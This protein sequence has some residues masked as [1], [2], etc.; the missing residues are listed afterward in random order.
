MCSKTALTTRP[1]G[2]TAKRCAAWTRPTWSSASDRLRSGTSTTRTSFPTWPYA[3]A[4][5]VTRY[6]PYVTVH[7]FFCYRL[8]S[9]FSSA[10][11]SGRWFWAS[12]AWEGLLPILPVPA[13]WV[14][15]QLKK[16]GHRFHRCFKFRPIPHYLLIS[17]IYYTKYLY[18]DK[19]ISF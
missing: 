13:G 12:S 7:F 17:A 3:N 16:T 18:C 15:V 4:I 6:I 1:S 10:D 5:T 19:C 8:P 11:L 9:L 14:S 2:W